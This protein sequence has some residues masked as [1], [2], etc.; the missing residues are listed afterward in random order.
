MMLL[1]V[2]FC[3]RLADTRL[4]LEDAAHQ[5]ARAASLARTTVAAQSDA[6]SAATSALATAGVTCRTVDVSVDTAGLRPG[7]TV[8]AT[9]TCVVG[10]S[11]VTLLGM[12]GATTL[13]ASFS[14][15]IDIYRGN[16]YGFTNSEA[17]SGVNRSGG[18]R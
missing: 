14:S 4:R 2:V 3:G 13:S 1:F 11:D 18:D 9:V 12:P 6:Q 10:L 8:T 7:A 17:V 16:V 5:A 15:P